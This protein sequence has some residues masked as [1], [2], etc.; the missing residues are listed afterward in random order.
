MSITTC[1]RQLAC[2]A[3]LAFVSPALFAVTETNT[4]DLLNKHLAA[5]GTPE[6]RNAKSRVVEGA[7]T[8]KIL[9]GGS[10]QVQGKS[11]F[12]SEGEKVRMLLKVNLDRYHGEQFIYSGKKTDVA[13]T[14][15]DKTWSEFGDFLR[16]QDAPLR[17]GLLG[18]A[19]NTTW[20]LLN[21]EAH[22]ANISYEGLKNIDGHQLYAMRYKPKKG[23]DLSIMLYFD[24]ETFRHVLTV[25]TVN[26]A[27]GLG[28]IGYEPTPGS[29]LSTGAAETES[30]RRNDAHYRIEERFSDFQT[31][32]GVTLPSRYDLRFSEELQNGFS[33]VIEWE[34][35]TTQVLN[36]IGLDP[37]NFEIH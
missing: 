22:K 37:K 9:V 23:T 13:G 5:I 27:S 10:G 17:E 20:P 33:K 7:A 19:L 29:T 34:V 24:P 31:V 30:A 15:T 1:T 21:L 2:L 32:D 16:S 35:S 26:R 28:S 25:Y 36:N 4:T 6:V 12:A 8:Y 3:V 18:G 14:Y 11:V